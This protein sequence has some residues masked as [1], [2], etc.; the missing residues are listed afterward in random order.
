MC[1]MRSPPPESS[2]CPTQH[3]ITLAATRPPE[4]TDLPEPGRHRALA[5][6]IAAALALAVLIGS[7]VLLAVSERFA[8]RHATRTALAALQQTGGHMRDQLD[9]GMAYRY[10]ELRI[11]AGLRDLQS[12]APPEQVRALLERVQASFPLYAWLGYVQRNGVVVAA[13]NDMLTGLDVAAR[14]WF[15]GGLQGAFVGDVHTAL[16]LSKLLPARAEP[17]RFVDIAMPVLDARG[18]VQFVLGAHLSWEWAIDLHRSLIPPTAA[19]AGVQL[20]V[21]DAAGQ[22]LL[23]PP[24]TEGQPLALGHAGDLRRATGAAMQKWGDGASYATAIVP[25]VGRGNY[26]GLGWTVVVRQ[27]QAAAFADYHQLR[28]EMLL[29]GLAVCMLAALCA[30]LVANRLTRPLLEL[31]RAVAARAQGGNE[32]VPRLHD[33][34]EV[35]LLSRALCEATEENARHQATLERRI[36][37]RTAELQIGQKRLRTMT[38]NMPALVADV[39]RALRFRFANE[40]YRDWFGVDPA[41]LLGNTMAS[42]YGE[43]AVRDW[44]HEIDCVFRGERVTFERCMTV[45]GKR[46]YSSATYLPRRDA[47]GEVDG[48]YAL[49][50]DMT[51][52]KELALRLE[53]E[54]LHDA[55]T[56][57]PNRRYLLQHLPRALARAD[58]LGHSL[59]LLFLDLNGFKAVNDQHGHEAGDALLRQVGARLT[60]ALRSTDTVA[61]LSGDEFVL[62]LEPVADGQVDGHGMAAKIEACVAAPYTLDG[63]TVSISV[64]VGGAVYPPG[65]GRSAEELLSGADMAMYEAKRAGK[66]GR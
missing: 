22:V 30:P 35:D 63:T 8:G 53:T 17:W 20:F 32:P 64:S 5:V 33:Y 15:Q 57:L 25:T 54:A 18:T 36:A 59:C 43:E 42:L 52:T 10:E 41:A 45:R 12:G 56:G 21:V 11:L 37:E 31:T 46:Q 55:L 39:D 1:T 65:S 50:F 40:T 44:Q 19:R 16:L 27:P 14:P 3:A 51:A 47:Q 4:P 26:P 60:G 66:A 62:V 23:G 6:W 49:V 29:A 61:R 9:R 2:P 38:D 28:R 34:R 7:L 48:F 58:R 13:T 24:G